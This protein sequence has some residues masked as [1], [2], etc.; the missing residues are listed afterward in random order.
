MR[1]NPD[2]LLFSDFER[3]FLL[4]RRPYLHFQDSSVSIFDRP[5]GLITGSLLCA[6][7]KFQG[8][9]QLPAAPANNRVGGG[10]LPC[11]NWKGEW[12][13]RRWRRWSCPP[14]T[15]LCGFPWFHQNQDGRGDSPRRGEGQLVCVG[16]LVYPPLKKTKVSEKREA[17]NHTAAFIAPEQ[18]P[19]R[20]LPS[21]GGRLW[22]LMSR[23]AIPPS[24]GANPTRGGGGSGVL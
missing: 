22:S 18:W 14:P 12:R 17:E 16:E 11:V 9:I 19:G 23:Y 6:R 1:R 13:R 8:I 21:S 3:R 4:T 24:F 7:F 10:S 2:V 20:P 15:S 5:P